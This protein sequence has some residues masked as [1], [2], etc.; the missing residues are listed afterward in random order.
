MALKRTSHWRIGGLG[1]KFSVSWKAPWIGAKMP[2]ALLTHGITAWNRYTN[3]NCR[4]PLH[5]TPGIFDD[6][7]VGGITEQPGH[8]EVISL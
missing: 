5:E 7:A 4:E 6:P 1:I 2:G 3:P 8:T